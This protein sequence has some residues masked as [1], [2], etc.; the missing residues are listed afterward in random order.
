VE[1]EEE[2]KEENPDVSEFLH[3]KKLRRK[4]WLRRRLHQWSE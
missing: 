1:E 3:S 4:I 2:E